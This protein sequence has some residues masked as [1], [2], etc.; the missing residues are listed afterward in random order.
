MSRLSIPGAVPHGYIHVIARNMKH[1]N[2]GQDTPFCQ[3]VS[4]HG[5]DCKDF[6][7]KKNG[8]WREPDLP[9]FHGGRAPP[10]LGA[11]CPMGLS[12]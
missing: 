9:R 3:P 10:N 5:L 4:V 2:R 11:R 6:A 1:V 8:Y 7:V 12:H